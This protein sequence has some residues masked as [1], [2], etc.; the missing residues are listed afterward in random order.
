MWLIADIGHTDFSPQNKILRTKPQGETFGDLIDG[1]KSFSGNVCFS[2]DK[3]QLRKTKLSLNLVCLKTSKQTN[4]TALQV[5][6]NP[7]W[8]KVSLLQDFSAQ[9]LRPPP[10]ACAP[11]EA[12][13]S[14][15][16]ILT[17]TDHTHSLPVFHSLADKE[18]SCSNC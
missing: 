1:R 15:A 14:K 4:P 5:V 2:C 3:V 11:S 17:T 13:A 7:R 6:N 10:L 16:S 9:V 18:G 12:K 8:L